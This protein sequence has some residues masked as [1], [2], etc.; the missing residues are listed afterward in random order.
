M[1]KER[2]FIGFDLGA[3][4]GR[5]VVG[6]F[7]DQNLE[8][9]E[10][11]RFTTHNIQYQNGFYWDILAIFQELVEG[12]RRA[13]KKFSSQFDGIGID[14]WGVDYVLIDS[15]ERILGYPY[16]YRDSRTDT[17]MEEAFKI[18]SKEN[19]YSNTGIQF[20]QFNT[21]F[22]LLAEKK[23]RLNLLNCSDRMLLMPDFLNFLLTGEKKAEYT[24]A[25]TSNL[26][27]PH[28]KNWQWNLI[29]ALNLPRNIFPE[30]VQ[31]GTFL[32]P[33]LDSIS[34]KVGLDK[35]IPVYASAGHDTASAVVSIPSKG[36]DWA[37]LSS[38]T[39]SLM[40][41]E[42]EKPI[43]T[44]EAMNYNFTN[45]GG[46]GNTIRFLKNIIGLWPIQECKR[47]WAEEGTEFTYQQLSDLAQLTENTNAWI[48]LDDPRFLKTGNMPNKV[49]N[50]LKETN[51][52]VKNE[53]G[54]IIRVILESLA[55][56]YKSTIDQIEKVTGKKIVVLN[57][58]GGGIQNELLM[59]LTADAIGRPII[60]GPI[61]GAIIGNIGTIAIAS[62]TVSN[63]SEWRSI[64][65][66]SFD[67][68]KYYP[69]NTNY[70]KQNEKAY[71][72]ILKY[73]G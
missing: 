10:V 30:I 37:F 33:L 20:A 63:L 32:A 38:G 72:G 67:V 41:V 65:E 44:S 28:T 73:R 3:E 48:D 27:D 51:Q 12:L 24:I 57:A 14:T 64:V 5:C 55:Y 23:N 69:T 29:D 52:T 22:Q 49:V 43:L 8:L 9:H 21:L 47:F 19:I 46:V 68:K 17:I 42:L 6:V 25:S 18:V 36:S 58:V 15:D 56:S 35:N 59:Q 50:Y 4:S 45:E 31:P 13:K 54:F 11:Y 53:I 62:G 61:E 39:W 2:K 66:N 71:R 16:H 40:G 26:L 1:E 34:D 60:A 7:K 70:F